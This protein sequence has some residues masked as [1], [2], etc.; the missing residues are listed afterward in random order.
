MNISDGQKVTLKADIAGATE[1]K[2]V[3]NGVELANSEEYRYGVS[4]SSHTLTIK[5]ASRKDE[6]ILTCMGKTR[7]GVVKC[8]YDLTL[9]KEVSGAP[10]FLSQPRSQ[11]VNAGQNVLFT[12]EISGEPSPDVEW[13][14]DKVPV[15]SIMHV[16]WQN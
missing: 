1:V 6:G 13:F 3:L 15:S 14:K 12:C 7:E 9:S 5:Q 11:N 10:T 8:Q 4:G 16:L 2:W